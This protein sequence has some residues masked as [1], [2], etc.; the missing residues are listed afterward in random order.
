MATE[1]RVNSYQNNWQ[2][3]SNVLALRDGGF[4]VTWQSYFNEYDDTDISTTYVAAQFYNAQAEPVGDEM[5]MRA[6]DGGYSGTPQATQLENGN[7]VLTWTETPDDDIFSSGAHIRA[8]I[9]DASGAALS[10][11]IAVDTV[12]SFEAVAPDVV[13]TGSGGFVVS[14]GID[15]SGKKADEVYARAYTAE[16][17]A[18]GQDKVL[19]T[20]SN[21]FDELV[22]KSAEL[23]NGNSVIIWNSEAAISDGTDDGRNEIRASLLDE[24]G[25]VIKSDFGLTP[26]FGGAGGAWSDN[27]NYGY[28]VAEGR[29]GG[30]VV[31]NLDWT[32][33]KKDDGT[34]G[35]YFSAYNAKGK[36]IDGPS[37][38]FEKGTVVGDVEMARLSNGQYVV[39]WSQQSLDDSDIG[40]DAYAIILSAS[41]KPVGKVFTVG[42]DVTKYDE[43][44]DVSVDGLQGGGFVISYMSESIDADGEGVAAT[45][46]APGN[47]GNAYHKVD[48]PAAGLG[49]TFAFGPQPPAT[50]ASE[51][52]HLADFWAV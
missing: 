46:Y 18:L 28:A 42:T 10:D 34:M 32:P 2:R 30:F 1:F 4:L 27:E 22:T 41:G 19:N 16:G 47:R 24:E 49:D 38:I 29:K 6:L 43:Q 31:A 35:I 15:G 9:F 26:H 11:V 13:A 37:A 52:D 21:Q 17:Q 50:D 25:T 12:E 7:I 23:S 8:Q 36:E 51:L 14:F 40:D 20:K 45:Y 39:A 3:D 48:A 44:A 33:S 5:V